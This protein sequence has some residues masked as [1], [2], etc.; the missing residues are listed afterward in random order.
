MIRKTEL[1]ANPVV[2]RKASGDGYLTQMLR[3][4]ALQARDRDIELTYFIEMA[5]ICSSDLDRKEAIKAM[6]QTTIA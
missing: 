6:G 3:E 2:V 1:R 5:V 4:L